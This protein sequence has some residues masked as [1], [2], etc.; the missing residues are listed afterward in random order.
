MTGNREHRRI[1][2]DSLKAAIS[3]ARKDLAAGKFEGWSGTASSSSPPMLLQKYGSCRVVL[4]SRNGYGLAH[5][6]SRI[7]GPR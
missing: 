3:A 5:W 7:M 1:L 2:R 4:L 6:R